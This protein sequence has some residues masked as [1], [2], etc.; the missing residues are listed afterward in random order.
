[1]TGGAP[2]SGALSPAESTAVSVELRRLRLAAR[3]TQAQLAVRL[4]CA[5]AW[6]SKR[7]TGGALLTQ[8][9]VWRIQAALA[10]PAPVP[11]VVPRQARPVKATRPVQPAV[12]VRSFRAIPATCTCDWR[13]TFERRRVSGWELARPAARCPNHGKQ[14]PR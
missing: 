7:E 11:P 10:A 1:M 12:R 3:L 13:V 6:V 5:V 8:A 9:E 2:R 14:A 4:G